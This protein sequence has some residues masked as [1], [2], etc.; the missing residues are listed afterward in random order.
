MSVRVSAAKAPSTSFELLQWPGSFLVTPAAE[1][2]AV[3]TIAVACTAASRR[4]AAV[5]GHYRRCEW[6]QWVRV[7]IAHPFWPLARAATTGVAGGELVTASA[8]C[9]TRVSLCVVGLGQ[10]RF[11][12]SSNRI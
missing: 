5:L 10:P 3:V 12:N 1:R 2:I 6:Y 7:A 11:I 9:R 4:L 8:F